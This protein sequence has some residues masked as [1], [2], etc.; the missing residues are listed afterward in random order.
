M[1]FLRDLSRKGGDKQMN[2][3]NCYTSKPWLKFYPEGVQSEIEIPIQSIPQAFDEAVARWGKEKTSII[4][5]GRHINFGELKDQVDRFATALWDLGVRKGDRI[6]VYLVNCPQTVIAFM[7]ALKI[8]AIV[9]PMNPAYVVPEVKHRLEDTGAETIVCMDIL[10]NR[11]EQTGIHLK[12]V[13]LTNI[14][15]YLPA[16]KEKLE[17]S[18]LPPVYDKIASP[19][20]DIYTSEGIY[21]FQD[22]IMK[23][24]P[25]PSAVEVDPEEDI[26]VLPYTG[27]TTGLPKGVMIT[28]YYVM[29]AVTQ[30]AAFCHYLEDGKEV[31]PGYMPFFHIAGLGQ[32]MLR[33]IIKGYTNVIFSNP[34]LGDILSSIIEYGISYLPG[35]PAML[36]ALLGLEQIDQVNWKQLKAVLLGADTLLPE[37]ARQWEKRTGI[38]PMMAWGLTEFTAASCNPRERPKPGSIGIPEPNIIAAIVDPDSTEF[39]PLGEVGEILLAGSPMM[40]GY[41][42]HPEETDQAIVEIDGRKWVRTGDLARMDDDGYLF[43]YGRRKYMIKHKGYAIFPPEI[44]NVL[45]AYPE[46]R[47]A[48]VVGIP[49]PKTGE[50][51]HAVLVLRDGA[52]ESL[53]EQEIWEYCNENLAHIKIP[54]TIAFRDALPR[55]QVGKVD[56]QSIID[57]LSDRGAAKT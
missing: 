43:F 24:E 46:I 30:D 9:S 22:L 25:N 10:Y 33:S 15:E 49:N 51:I 57:A 54:K 20:P 14:D 35:S 50:D 56:R 39:L 5:Y 11:V 45:T 55:T 6:V 36:E 42:K 12:H 32:M 31:V 19:S 41:W 18:V 7:G 48:A 17:S 16:P 13:I 26:A 23:Y 34:D 8:G 38:V 29:A 1:V 47:E 53:S 44:E 27:G 21:G 3:T 37:T 4:F 52:G 2:T 40:K 28:H